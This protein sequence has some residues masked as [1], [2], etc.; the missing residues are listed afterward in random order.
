M[1]QPEWDKQDCTGK[2]W[3]AEKRL[4]GEEEV[5][6]RTNCR[7]RTVGTRLPLLG[8]YDRTVGAW[9]PGQ[10]GQRRVFAQ[11]KEAETTRPKN[12]SKAG[13]GRSVSTS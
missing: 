13:G 5:A 10:D 11:F 12:S 3:N 1:G 4:P 8:Y 7:E 9:L 2:K 6:C